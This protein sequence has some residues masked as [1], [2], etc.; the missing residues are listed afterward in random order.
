VEARADGSV[1]KE[2]VL[3][4][5]GSTEAYALAQVT[6]KLLS[7][8]GRDGV[9]G[10]A[11]NMVIRPDAPVAPTAE[12]QV[13]ARKLEVQWMSKEWPD[14]TSTLAFAD[15][16]VFRGIDTRA[17]AKPDMLKVL[18]GDTYLYADGSVFVE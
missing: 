3:Q 18:V 2:E 9:I 7:Y 6:N 5:Y 13:E 11:N 15:G 4:E 1:F 17:P 12:Q 14:G 16:V 10:Y 8:M